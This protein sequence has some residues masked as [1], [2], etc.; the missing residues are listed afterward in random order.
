MKPSPCLL[1]RPSLTSSRFLMASSC[2]RH[3]TSRSHNS[4]RAHRCYGVRRL[5]ELFVSFPRGDWFSDNMPLA[6]AISSSSC[7]SIGCLTCA[8]L[9]GLTKSRDTLCAKIPCH[10]KALIEHGRVIT[11]E[12]RGRDNVFVRKFVTAFYTLHTTSTIRI[13]K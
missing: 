6:L 2:K 9:D 11:S 12:G 7:E 13:F 3:L 5:L 4:A 10:V 1:S 8:V